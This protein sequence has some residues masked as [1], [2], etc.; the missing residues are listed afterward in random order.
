VKG[1]YDEIGMPAEEP[2]VYSGRYRYKLSDRKKREKLCGGCDKYFP[3]E[4]YWRSGLGRI[5]SRCPFCCKLAVSGI[6][7]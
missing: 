7:A 3:R 1:E 4:H 2:W 5:N 6:F